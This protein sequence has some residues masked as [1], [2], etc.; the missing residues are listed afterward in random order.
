MYWNHRI[1]I[2]T[3]LITLIILGLW[4]L[5]P[6]PALSQEPE[7][8]QLEAILEQFKSSINQEFEAF[9]SANDSIFLKYMKDSW[10]SFQVYAGEQRQ[11][12]KPAAQPMVEQ[13]VL[14]ADSSPH[15]D[16]RQQF[17]KSDEGSIES[18]NLPPE[19]DLRNYDA[20]NFY[21]SF[22]G[23]PV[24][25]SA[26]VSPPR[27]SAPTKD[28]ITAY[29]RF[30]SEDPRI[31]ELIDQLKAVAGE[32]K[33]NDWGTFNLVRQASAQIAKTRNEQKLL[34]WYILMKNGF[35]VKSGYN[36]STVFLL[37]ETAT[38]IFNVPYVTISGIRYYIISFP[39]DE[40]PMSGLQSYTAN[41]PGESHPVSF[42]VQEYPHLATNLFTKPLTWNGKK[43][44]VRLNRSLIDYL[45]TYPNCEL[46]IYFQAPL[47]PDARSSMDNIVV[48]VLEGKSRN[49]Q[50]QILLDLVQRGIPYRQDLEQFGEENYLFADE[51]LYYPYAD[52]EDRAVLFA[53]LVKQYTGLEVVGLD[54]PDHVSTAVHF[55]DPIAGDFILVNN[56][57]YYICDPTYIGAKPGMA[58]ECMRNEKP[59]V[60]L[61]DK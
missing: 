10:A 56:Q 50:V 26:S 7:N 4:F 2:K 3:P 39:P 19:T 51:T 15:K 54:Y 36:S 49:E 18:S 43:L 61:V 9:K 23:Q 42:A 57:R 14:P 12:P 30:C 1:R 60:I 6:V 24:G 13:E 55:D 20:G 25:L 33:L 5:L 47:S 44:P 27:L 28:Q 58:M 37:V 41:Y 11:K 8:K 16:Q 52:C 46:Q 31:G 22:F 59:D 35:N 40:E 38:R 48:P 53:R 17:Q 32:L 45:N 29:F 34:T 21:M